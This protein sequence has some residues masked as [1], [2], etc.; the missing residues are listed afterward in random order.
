MKPA[1][2]NKLPRTDI[3][4]KGLIPE[5]GAANRALARYNGVLLGIP[6]PEIL[7]SPLT[8]QEAVLSSR[9]EGTRATLVE[10]LK[11]EAGEKLPQEQARLD[12]QEIMN[13]RRAL[14]SAETALHSR[15][16][17]LNLLLNLHSILMEDVRGRYRGRGR[18]RT[19]QNY[20]GPPGGDIEDA[21]FVPPDPSR[22]LEYMDNWEKYYHG[23]ERDPLVQLALIHAQFEVI[24][25]FVDGNGRLGRMLVPLFLMEKE[26]LARPTFY[27]SSF[28]E[29]RRQEYYEALRALDG[30]E[31]WNRW[32]RFF[33]NALVEQSSRNTDKAQQ[34]LALRERLAERVLGLTR[35]RFAVP[36]LGRIFRQP[37]LVPTSLFPD[38]GL[39]TKP[40]VMTLLRKMRDEGML[41]VLRE[42]S[43]RRPQIL[44]LAELVNL[45]EGRKVI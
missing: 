6:N 36:L 1:V 34:I 42:P 11:H 43:G 45:V 4:W 7:L 30:A 12:V 24:H 8:T 38:E 20:I 41:L 18:F 40:A 27:I 33:L 16:F 23:E 13:Y 26:L 44:A 32:I 5:L 28:F 15:P 37:I 35:S 10:V 19:V 22:V 31:T 25:P 3:D 29:A 21:Y 39:P 14:R 17:N 2:P 9:I